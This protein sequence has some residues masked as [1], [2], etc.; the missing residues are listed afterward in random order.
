MDPE[1]HTS[2]KEAAIAL[3]AAA[4]CESQRLG[5][6]VQSIQGRDVEGLPDMSQ[7][8]RFYAKAVLTAGRDRQHG[9]GR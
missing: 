8:T 9:V 4:A 1:L 3:L 6:G 2:L 5:P 7:A